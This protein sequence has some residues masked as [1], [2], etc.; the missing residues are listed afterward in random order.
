MDIIKIISEELGLEEKNVQTVVSL[1]DGGDSVPFISRYRKDFTG[2]MQDFQVRN[3][4]ERL[5][6]LRNLEEKKQ[7]AYKSIEEQGKMTPEIAQALEDARTIAEVEDIYRPYKL[8]KETRVEKALKA[9]LDNLAKFIYENRVEENKDQLL[10]EEATKYI[11]ETYPT[12]E[13]CIKGA[14]DVIAG[15][16]SDNPNYRNRIKN[17]ARK[18]AIL[19]AKLTKEP[20]KNVYDNYDGFE[21]LLYKVPSFR[22][23]AINR[24]VKEDCLTKEIILDDEK[25]LSEI[26]WFEIP[27]ECVYK[28]IVEEAI[29]DSYKRL[30]KPSIENELFSDLF[31][32]SEDESI[33]G[34]KENLKQVLLE[35]PVKGKKIM[36]IDPGIRTGC[37]WVVLNENG[38]IL[39]HGISLLTHRGTAYRE[40][41]ETMID[42]LTKHKVDLV[43]LGNGTGGR[44]TERALVKDILP[45]VPN[46]SYVFV[47]E[48]GASIY[49]ASKLAQKEFPEY[50]VTTRGAISIGRRLIDPLSELVKIP[51]ESIGV[52][53]Y[54]HDMNQTKLKKALGGEVEDV[55]NYVGVDLNIATSHILTYISGLSSTL[56]KN[57]IDY[58][59]KNRGFR[60]REELKS[61]KGFGDKAFTNCAGFLRIADGYEPLDNTAVHPESYDI[62]KAILNK[63]NVDL[64]GDKS[65]LSEISDQQIKALATELNVGEHTL[66]DIIKELIKPSRDP[67][68]E[69]RKPRLIPNVDTIEKVK[70]GMVMEGIVR[71]ITQFGAFVD[72]GVHNEGLV[73]VS[74]ITDQFVKDIKDFL[75]I[76][77]LVKVKVIEV[78]PEKKAIKL[79]M[80]NIHQLKLTVDEM[81]E[82]GVETPSEE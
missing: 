20:T 15:N 49:S 81:A 14:Q 39:E 79:T 8:K 56:A 57:I 11:C 40:A 5:S 73:H 41:V 45:E 4:E 38:D 44:E 1:L 2:N 47:S 36:A 3:V 52:G 67:R 21:S 82:S 74:Q 60:S 16:V 29:N 10:I 62:A 50:D 63:F 48:S 55:V 7:T 19:K 27:D 77:D 23:L 35:P 69:L 12:A 6:Q 46:C 66:H 28:D 32:K 13:D 26:I 65:K 54:Q 33:E 59:Q 61:V 9:G 25:N 70:P 30:I 78:I 64:K 68:K 42:L 34:F 51:P 24:G 22:C 58:R 76:G 80:K 72:I 31:D 18:T 17:H 75:K 53:Q 37:K 43:A 71:N